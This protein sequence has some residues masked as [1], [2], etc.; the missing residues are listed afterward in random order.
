MKTT[1][2]LVHREETIYITSDGKEFSDQSLA[3]Q[4]EYNFVQE[5]LEPCR[6]YDFI[7][8]KIFS[9]DALIDDILFDIY[10][11]WNKDKDPEI[12]KL[13]GT[14]YC[15]ERKYLKSTNRFQWKNIPVKKAIKLV[16][17][18]IENYQNIL[19]AKLEIRKQILESIK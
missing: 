4:H 11:T 16:N 7:N 2:K 3:R 1:T 14:V 6:L 9:K 19:N 17:E 18:D 13:Q 12:P 10:D 5:R 8:T 15:I